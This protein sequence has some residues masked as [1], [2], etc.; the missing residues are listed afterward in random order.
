M[1]C[2]VQRNLITL[3]RNH[4]NLKSKPEQKFSVLEGMPIL[5]NLSRGLRDTFHIQLWITAASLQ[6]I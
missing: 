3:E 4:C 6:T 5:E 1:Q 2:Q